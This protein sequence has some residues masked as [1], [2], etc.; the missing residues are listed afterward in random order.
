MGSGAD[1]AG[2]CTH[3]PSKHQWC[4]LC[5]V[6]LHTNVPIPKLPT[7]PLHGW[8]AWA[9]YLHRD[10]HLRRHTGGR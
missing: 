4:R 8:A 5:R 1:Y 9:V 3:G 2:I 7:G 6:A 10:L